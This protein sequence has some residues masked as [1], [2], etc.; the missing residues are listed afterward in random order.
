MNLNIITDSFIRIK[1]GY[2]QKL[3][4]VLVLKSK[5]ITPILDMLCVE[6]F[7]RGYTSCLVNNTKLKVLLKYSGGQGSLKDIKIISKSGRRVYVNVNDL[8]YIYSL[9]GLGCFIISTSKGVLTLREALE[10]NTGGELICY[11]S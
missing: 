3:E 2:D 10:H 8:W 4:S 9:N 11:V 1:N 6:G 5:K 7:I